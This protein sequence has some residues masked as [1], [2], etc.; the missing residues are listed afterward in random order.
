MLGSLQGAF[1]VTT[2]HFSGFGFIHDSLASL[3]T[4][5]TRVLRFIVGHDPFKRLFI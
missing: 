2:L 1:K 4:P 3:L 5:L